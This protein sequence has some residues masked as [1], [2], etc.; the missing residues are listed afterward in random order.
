M[1]LMP[2]AMERELKARAVA[3]ERSVSFLIRKSCEKF[4][5]EVSDTFCGSG[6][7]DT[8]STRPA[9]RKSTP[10]AARK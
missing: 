6:V 4:L 1:Y 9:P 7:S 8:R 2:K 10:R 5:T 3:S